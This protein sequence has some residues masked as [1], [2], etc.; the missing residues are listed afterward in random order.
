MPQ[1]VPRD[2]AN[3]GVEVSLPFQGPWRVENSPAQRVPSHGT[4]LFGGR[5][6]IDFV[7]VNKKHRT[8]NSR[9][10]RTFL[11]TEPPEIFFAF[12]QPILAPARGTIVAVHDNEPDHEARRSQLALIPYALG[13]AGRA[14]RG[15][16][17]IAGN[18]VIISLA[19]SNTFIALAH[20]K[21][22]SIRVSVGQKVEEGQHIADCGNSGNS[23]QPHV[24]MQAMDSADLSI[25]KGV[26]MLFRHFREWRPG[27]THVKVRKCAVPEER[28]VVEQL[29]A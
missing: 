1:S 10:W 4:N 23:T 16:S 28:A 25:A 27:S 3:Q 19:E 26:P 7:G 6:A 12:G 2:T 18:Y 29:A 9:S 13:Q 14:R 20:F 11:A 5:Y 21:A 22:G 15:I 17:A 24:H 8:A